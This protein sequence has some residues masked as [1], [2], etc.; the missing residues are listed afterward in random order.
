MNHVWRLDR[1]ISGMKGFVCDKCGAGPVW[2][3]ETVG[4]SNITQEGKKKGIDPNC[5]M[6][7][8]DQTNR[9]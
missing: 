6:S 7:L 4:K 8:V 2:I 1:R 3:S 9:R 5:L